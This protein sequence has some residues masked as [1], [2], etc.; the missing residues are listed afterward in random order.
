MYRH[1]LAG[2]GRPG[3]VAADRAGRVIGGIRDP[4]NQSGFQDKVPY[5]SVLTKQ[6]RNRFSNITTF[7]GSELQPG[8]PRGSVVESQMAALVQVLSRLSATTSI[9]TETLKM[10]AIFSGA[11]LLASVL[12]A[13]CG[14][15]LGA[16]F[17]CA[18][19]RA[20]RFCR[21]AIW[22]LTVG[23]FSNDLLVRLNSC[24]VFCYC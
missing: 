20:L 1:K 9:E 23:G 13:A 7:T 4:K 5:R 19:D 16:E 21:A 8:S 17:F 10:L 22:Q 6:S 12:F 24:V 2:H 15:D 18:R 11:G 3:L 14:L